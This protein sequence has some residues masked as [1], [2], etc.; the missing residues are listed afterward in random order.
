MS[1]TLDGT[2]GIT[3]P[4]VTSDSYTGAL[5]VNASAPDNS[6]V[7]NSSGNV[8][9]G[10]S[11][12]AT[13]LHLQ[14]NISGIYS[15]STGATNADIELGGG[16]RAPG[17]SSFLIRQ[18]AAGEAQLLNREN[19][20]LILGTNFTERARIDSSGNLLVGTTTPDSNSGPGFKFR[21]NGESAGND[22][23]AIVFPGSTNS[24]VPFTL[25][26]TGANAYRFYVGAG[27]TIYAT[28][29]TITALSDRRLKENI[30]DLDDGLSVVMSLTP[31]KF[32][33]KEGKGRNVKNDRGWIADEIKQ[34]VPDLVE[35][36][37]DPAPE[38]EAP[39]ETVRP[40]LVPILVK[41]IQE[42]QAIIETQQ[43]AIAGLTARVEALE[44][45]NV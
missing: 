6:L 26:S 34:V 20:S 3:T 2:N 13:T 45:N 12:P 41:A 22:R 15:R 35:K 21:K 28:S 31:R 38:G 1:I 5:N 44:A 33:W 14:S 29:S 10:T 25:Y 9:I 42:Q 16:N 30:R 32:D 39:Y 18:S 37:I 4:D 36:S 17:I 19:A 23:T 7:V 11:S 40:D 8:G 27:G 43:Q 24:N